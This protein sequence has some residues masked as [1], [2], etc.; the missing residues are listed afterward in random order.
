MLYH[1]IIQ[2]AAASH[3]VLYSTPMRTYHVTTGV[4]VLVLGDLIIPVDSSSTSLGIELSI[5]LKAGV[6]LLRWLWGA[7]A[8]RSEHLQLKQEALGSISSGY[9][10]YFS[11]PAGSV[12]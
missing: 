8:R 2:N 3:T 1:M 4:G 6:E 10:W 5:T 12:T 7:I 9:P 11:L